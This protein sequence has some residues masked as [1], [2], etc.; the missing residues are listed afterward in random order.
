MAVGLSEVIAVHAGVAVAQTAVTA[1]G[2]AVAAGEK[3]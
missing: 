3:I 2:A 1:S